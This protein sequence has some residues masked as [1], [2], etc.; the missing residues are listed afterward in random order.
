[1]DIKNLKDYDFKDKKVIVRVDYN[2]PIDDLGNVTDNTR[3]I[4]SLDTIKYLNNNKS[5]IIL[6]SHLGRPKG[7]D[8]KLRMNNIAKEIQKILDEKKIWLTVIKLDDCIGED[9]KK[10]IDSSKGNEIFLLENLRFY[11]EEEKNDD[12]FSKMLSEIADCYVS[13]AFGTVHRAHA[14]THGIT[15]YIPSFAGFLVEKEVMALSNIMENP[16]RPF[17]AIIGCAKIKDKLNAI[18]SLLEKSDKVFFGGAIVFSFFKSLGY[19]IGKSICEE[20][21]TDIK[22]IYEKYKDK[23]ILPN[24]I[25]VTEDIKKHEKII[26]VDFDKMPNDMIGVDIGESSIKKFIEQLNNAKT[27][28]WNGPMGIFEIEEFSNGTN[29]LAD[30]ISKLK[31]KNVFTIIGGGDTVSAI[32]KFNFD[33]FSHVSTGGGAFLEF[34]EGKEL[35]GISVLKK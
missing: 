3:I 30:F 5:K 35:P 34:I 6:M 9:I 14:S 18:Q 8:D 12:S 1:M 33:N 11:V 27:I 21:L 16:K 7:I 2:V 13:D 32:S 10:R 24:D 31:E 28:V 17:Y 15:K 25:I 20:D 26:T 4:A 19:E 22:N 23:I 29:Y